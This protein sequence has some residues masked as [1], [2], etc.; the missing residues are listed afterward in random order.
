MGGK[1]A[2][3]FKKYGGLEI[4]DCWDDYVPVG[5]Q[6]D[7]YRS[8]AAKHGEKIAVPWQIWPDKESFYA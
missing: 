3:I 4:V 2:A 8:V 1:S 7:F 5:K 6:T